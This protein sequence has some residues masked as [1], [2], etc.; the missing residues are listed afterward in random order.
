[1]SVR[2]IL[3]EVDLHLTPDSTSFDVYLSGGVAMLTYGDITYRIPEFDQELDLRILD[4]TGWT[5]RAGV[6]I[7]FGADS[8]WAATGAIRYTDGQLEI[9]DRD[10]APN[11][12]TTFD[13]GLFHFTVGIAFSF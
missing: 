6:D 5:V 4:D 13:Y 7:S 10:E 8:A 3:V 12:F 2:E 9:N 11:D 1:M